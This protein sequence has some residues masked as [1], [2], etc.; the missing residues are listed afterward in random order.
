MCTCVG[1]CMSQSVYGDQ[2]LIYRIC[3][4]LPSSGF[5]RS[6][7]DHLSGLPASA[8]TAEPSGQPI[9]TFLNGRAT[10]PFHRGSFLLLNHDYC[11]LSSVKPQTDLHGILHRVG[12]SPAAAKVSPSSLYLDVLSL[13][14]AH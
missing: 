7:S 9:C 14:R 3:S 11:F 5:Q 10:G 13:G 2:T 12:T 6:N 4:L 8:F 1:V